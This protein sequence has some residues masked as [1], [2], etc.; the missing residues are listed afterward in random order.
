MAGLKA[1][2]H[3]FSLIGLALIGAEARSQ[4]SS[5]HLYDLA[6]AESRPISAENPTG[7]TRWWRPS[8]RSWADGPLGLRAG[9]A[10]GFV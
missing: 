8:S 10:G 9:F 7:A 1:Y 3:Y 2:G 4:S 5:R 6:N